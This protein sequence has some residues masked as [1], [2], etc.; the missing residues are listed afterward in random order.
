MG[1]VALP[2]LDIGIYGRIFLKKITDK[3]VRKKKIYNQQFLNDNI[4]NAGIME[5]NGG[6]KDIVHD[7]I[8]TISRI[9]E[10]MANHYDLESF[11]SGCIMFT[12]VLAWAKGLT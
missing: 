6:W 11:M 5:K 1:V 4:L 2:I 3:K 8:L 7:N 10:Q 12:Y 9:S